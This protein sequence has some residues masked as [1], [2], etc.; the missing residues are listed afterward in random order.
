[1]NILAI[2]EDNK[3]LYF[4]GFIHFNVQSMG[5]PYLTPDINCSNIKKYDSIYNLKE[6]Q[7]MLDSLGFRVFSIQMPD[8]KKGVGNE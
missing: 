5:M 8:D 4:C 3:T 2:E 1:M 7:A 6:E